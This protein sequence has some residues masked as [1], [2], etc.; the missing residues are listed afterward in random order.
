[1]KNNLNNLEESKYIILLEK[2]TKFVDLLINAISQKKYNRY[3]YIYKSQSINYNNIKNIN[4]NNENF[5]IPN[6]IIFIL[7]K[8][9]K[10]LQK[11]IETYK[12]KK[13]ENDFFKKGY[14][15]YKKVNKEL[16]YNINIDPES[17]FYDLVFQYK[18][19]RNL[20]ITNEFLNKNTFQSCPL[21]LISQND[22]INYFTLETIENG[23]NSLGQFKTIWFLNRI[24]NDLNYLI[25]KSSLLGIPKKKSLSLINR[26]QKYMRA[27]REKA[28]K[29]LSK[30]QKKI[31]DIE[32]SK[33]D[34]SNLNKLITLEENKQKEK[35]KTFYNNI[36]QSYYS[37]YSQIKNDDNSSLQKKKNNSDIDLLK[38][39]EKKIFTKLQ[40]NS[41]RKKFKNITDSTFFSKINNNSFHSSI[42]I[43]DSINENKTLTYYNN[44]NINFNVNVKKN[45]SYINLN[46]TNIE[47]IYDTLKEDNELRNYKKEKAIFNPLLSFYYGEKK[48]QNFNLKKN[49]SEIFQKLNKLKDK[50]T[51]T[52]ISKIIPKLYPLRIPNHLKEKLEE[53]KQLDSKIQK[54]GFHFMNVMVKKNINFSKVNQN[55]ES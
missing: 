9:N 13:F 21:L 2:G 27:R 52:N 34:I 51:Y 29:D 32:Q 36:S 41:I 43:D 24:I 53:N 12:I 4:N 42:N 17:L 8:Y 19:K 10:L 7:S 48:V 38:N 35:D 54:L 40:R 16:F 1:M 30:F 14:Q 44:S 25:K 6:D 3:H 33:K 55:N 20:S 15:N 46:K 18:N 47:S 39:N 45:N 37:D 22:L 28:F 31:F 26:N 5:N 49:R 23:I 11:N 50:V